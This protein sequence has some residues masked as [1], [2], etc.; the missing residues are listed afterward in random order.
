MGQVHEKVVLKYIARLAGERYVMMDSLTKQQEFSATCLDTGTY[1][2]NRLHRIIAH[3]DN[4]FRKRKGISNRVLWFVRLCLHR[5]TEKYCGRIWMKSRAARIYGDT[6]SQ[7]M[8]RVEIWPYIIE[9]LKMIYRNLAL[10]V[11]SAERPH[12][13]NLVAIHSRGHRAIVRS[14]HLPL[15]RAWPWTLLG[16]CYRLALLRSPRTTSRTPFNVFLNPLLY[17]RQMHQLWSIS[18]HEC[19]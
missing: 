13:L 5:I 3:T 11:T 9:T 17:V 16:H 6:S 10:L 14:F 8:D 1:L 15:T 12:M 2:Y 4:F 18:Y 19:H 7:W